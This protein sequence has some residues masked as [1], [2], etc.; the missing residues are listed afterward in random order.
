[1][2]ALA[3]MGI[4]TQNFQTLLWAIKRTSHLCK[5]VLEMPSLKKKKKNH[6]TLG[7]LPTAANT[8]L[9]WGGIERCT[10]LITLA[11]V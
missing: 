8:K 1:M 7:S 4:Y 10:P 11:H 6:S 3:G 5:A 9:A 2:S